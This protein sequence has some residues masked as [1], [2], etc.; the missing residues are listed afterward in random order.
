MHNPQNNTQ[1]GCLYYLFAQREKLRS[2]RQAAFD[3]QQQSRGDTYIFICIYF[4]VR[5][6]SSTLMAFGARKAYTP[7]LRIGRQVKGPN[8]A[9]KSQLQGNF[10]FHLTTP[11]ILMTTSTYSPATSKLCLLIGKMEDFHFLN[12]TTSL[13]VYFSLSHIWF[14]ALVVD[15]WLQPATPPP[16]CC[17]SLTVIAPTTT[18]ITHLMTL[19]LL[20]CNF[21]LFY[22]A[23]CEFLIEN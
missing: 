9:G 19:I 7:R 15:R 1:S 22:S 20:S 6:K 3:I 11:Q 13:S 23:A 14:Q 17:N 18:T 4:A 8:C 16:H 12:H 5:N 21:L 10:L 2:G